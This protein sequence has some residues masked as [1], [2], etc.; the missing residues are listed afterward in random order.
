MEQ[1]Y[2]IYIIELDASVLT[3]KNFLN[4]NPEMAL[5]LPFLYVGQSIVP[6]A[7]RF[8]QHKMG[9]KGSRWVRDYGK[10]VRRK[11]IG[12]YERKFGKAESR[13]EALEIEAKV[14]EDLRSIGHGVWYN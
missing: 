13:E 5:D 9:H 10:W 2:Y 11:L 7:E 12:R 1:N 6:P 14:A 8:K 3:K 4:Q